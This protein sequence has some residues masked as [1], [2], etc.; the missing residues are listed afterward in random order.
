MSHH[1]TYSMR[2]RIEGAGSIASDRW[3]RGARY[4]AQ[5]HLHD[6][7]RPK[8]RRLRGVGAR[9]P[10]LG[11]APFVLDS[12]YRDRPHARVRKLKPKTAHRGV[13]LAALGG[14]LGLHRFYLDDPRGWLYVLLCWSGLPTVIGLLEALD[15]PRRVR[16]YDASAAEADCCRMRWLRKLQDEK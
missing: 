10:R 16:L 7:V 11:T 12:E 3:D 14:T 6:V 5:R 13:L 15:M 9:M 1:A 4:P 2:E 8:V